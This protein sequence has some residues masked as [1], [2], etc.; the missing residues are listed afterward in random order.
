[1]TH[2]H[3]A[4]S[5]VALAGCGAPPPAEQPAT[6]STATASVASIAP[7][8]SPAPPPIVAPAA[9]PVAAA[10]QTVAVAEPPAASASA[11]PRASA[12]A[13]RLIPPHM[14]HGRLA[15]EIIQRVVRENFGR[16]RLCYENNLRNSPN[17]QGRVAVRFVI[18][19]NGKVRKSE[20]AGSDMPDSETVACVVKAFR[21]L[22]FPPPDGGTVTVT[23]PVMF[24]P[25]G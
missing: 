5:L 6:I 12:G 13:T 22:T 9:P 17:L 14:V 10:P 16:F 8:E 21:E 23:Y 20:N 19:V 15:P 11:S 7:I 18:E 2:A 24:A 25:G 1:M 4:L 3:R